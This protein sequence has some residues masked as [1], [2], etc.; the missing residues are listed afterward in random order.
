MPCPVCDAV[1]TRTVLTLEDVPVHQHQVIRDHRAAREVPTGTVQLE[2]CP[3]CDHTWNAAFEADLLDY[4]TDYDNRQ[5]GSPAFAAYLDERIA[6]IVADGI[7]DGHIVEVGCGNGHFLTQL[8]GATGSRGTGF[9]PAYRGPATVGDVRFVRAFYG[10]ETATAPADRV[11]CRHVIE[12]V[13][14]PKTL[15]RAVRAALDRSPDARVIFECPDMSWIVR[16]QVIWDVFYEHAQYFSPTSLAALL[17]RE[18]FED[19]IVERAFRGQYLWATARPGAASAVPEGTRLTEAL[20]PWAEA[21]EAQRAGWQEHLDDLRETGAVVAWG[22]GA[23]GV[24]LARLGDPDAS[25]LVG[26]VDVNAGKQGAFVP[27]TGHPILAP[28]AL[29]AYDVRHVVVMNPAYLA[30]I[31]AHVRALGLDATVHPP[32]I[33][34]NSSSTTKLAS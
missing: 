21:F 16:N 19:V 2:H 25:R 6:H 17:R 30:E 26:L 29:H 34:C 12:H 1:D 10:P 18:G 8:C 11:V 20:G 22:A 24:T 32:E 27:G 14:D 23:K 9:D 13:P 33:P 28:Q 4:G 31:R 7:Q 3:A 15:V 5:D